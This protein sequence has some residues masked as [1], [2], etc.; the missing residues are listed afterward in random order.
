M[1]R[2]WLVAGG[3]GVAC[4]LSPSPSR[5]Y[6]MEGAGPELAVAVAMGTEPEVLVSG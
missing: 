1:S 4:T 6:S 2:D 3:V 5:V